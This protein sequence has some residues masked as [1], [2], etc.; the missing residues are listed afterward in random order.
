WP[1]LVHVTL[2][3]CNYTEQKVLR[4]TGAAPDFEDLPGNAS[5]RLIGV[6]VLTLRHAAE[7]AQ[8]HSNTI[9]IHLCVKR[10]VC[11]E[12]V[13]LFKA[14]R[15]VKVAPRPLLLLIEFFHYQG[16]GD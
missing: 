16:V 7:K 14:S 9:G 11:E 10:F 6:V 3:H 5:D 13:E 4:H 12:L 1:R 15:E 8:L 2:D